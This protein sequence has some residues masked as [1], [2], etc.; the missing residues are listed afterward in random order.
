MCVI[1]LVVAP[2]R[3]YR[4][5][6]RHKTIVHYVYMFLICTPALSPL[7]LIIVFYLWPST[8]SFKL[9]TQ[10]MIRGAVARLLVA[11]KRAWRAWRRV[12]RIVCV[13]ARMIVRARFKVRLISQLLTRIGAII[14]IVD[15][16]WISSYA[17]QSAAHLSLSPCC[18]VTTVLMKCI[19]RINQLHW[20]DPTRQEDSRRQR[21]DSSKSC[22]ARE[23]E[24]CVR[25]RWCRC[26]HR[27][28]MC[29]VWCVM[30]YS[31]SVS[32]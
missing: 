32:G 5:F 9:R 22:D 15:K 6:N 7:L 2:S 1:E 27:C 13:C 17:A 4:L 20:T 24:E 18:T 25:E 10:A 14:M 30:W 28:A 19:W 16:R 29:N 31:A 12:A 11:P 3:Y 23:Q 21:I 8:S 26:S